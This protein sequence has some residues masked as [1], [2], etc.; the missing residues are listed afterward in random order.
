M[1]SIENIY[2]VQIFLNGLEK[3]IKLTISHSY[4]KKNNS[5]KRIFENECHIR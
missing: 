1:H 5:N 2:A 4:A 3:L